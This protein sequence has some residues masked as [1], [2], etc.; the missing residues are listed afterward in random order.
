MTSH[1]KVCAWYILHVSNCNE[2]HITGVSCDEEGVLAFEAKSR[3]AQNRYWVVPIFTCKV[4]P[5]KRHAGQLVS[6]LFDA[7]GP[8]ELL[9]SEDT[10]PQSNGIHRIQLERVLPP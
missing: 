6:L 5:E 10:H 3:A 7:H 1:Y 9:C 4:P 8:A 2:F